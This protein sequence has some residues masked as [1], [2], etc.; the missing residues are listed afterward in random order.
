MDCDTEMASLRVEPRRDRV[1][2]FLSSLVK[3]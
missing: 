1:V 3:L 2:I